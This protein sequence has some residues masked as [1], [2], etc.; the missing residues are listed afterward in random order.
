MS[1]HRP[2]LTAREIAAY[3][4]GARLHRVYVAAGLPDWPGTDA[5]AET[6]ADDDARVMCAMGARAWWRWVQRGWDDHPA[7]RLPR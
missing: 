4:A 5:L 3:L 1:R 6:M 2:P 7:V